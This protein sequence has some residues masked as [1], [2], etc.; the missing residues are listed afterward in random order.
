M[1]LVVNNMKLNRNELRKA[2]AAFL[3]LRK[4]PSKYFE[5]TGIIMCDSCVGTGLKNYKKVGEHDF[6]WDT[7]EFCCKCLGVGYINLFSY[8]QNIIDGTYCVCA[9]CNGEGCIKCEHLGITDW[10]TNMMGG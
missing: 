6:A 10:V 8:D 9:E 2:S 1:L 7:S 3:F 5:E 4:Q